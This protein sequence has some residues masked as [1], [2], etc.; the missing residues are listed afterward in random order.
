MVILLFSFCFF[1][2]VAKWYFKC[3]KLNLVEIPKRAI[4]QFSTLKLKNQNEP[5]FV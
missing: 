5:R 3:E 4:E 1:G 2:M